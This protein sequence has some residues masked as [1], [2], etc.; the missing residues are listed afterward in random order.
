MK[1]DKFAK[2]PNS[3][4][5][6]LFLLLG[7]AFA[8]KG[9][10]ALAWESWKIAN[11]YN[12][13]REEVKR[14]VSISGEKSVRELWSEFSRK[15]ERYQLPSPPSP[16]SKGTVKVISVIGWGALAL[17]VAALSVGLSTGFN[18]MVDANGAL[19]MKIQSQRRGFSQIHSAPLI[20]S[21]HKRAVTNSTV[22]NISLVIAGLSAV[23]GAGLLIFDIISDK[24]NSSQTK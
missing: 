10:R 9:H 23:T 14:L 11:S 17:S 5:G 3:E 12:L 16:P 13:K 2:L 21:L 1:S 15:R 19:K 24:K 4:R 18:A 22:T 20:Q 8:A 7:I 6:E